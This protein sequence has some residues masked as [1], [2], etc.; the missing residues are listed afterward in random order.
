MKRNK[1]K[2]TLIPLLL[3]GSLCV[4]FPLSVS[5]L[6]APSS[7]SQTDSDILVSEE[8]QY[9]ED[10]SYIT[11]QIYESNSAATR[12][13]TYTKDGKKSITY[14]TDTGVQLW[15]YT[16]AG[17]FTVNPGVSATCTKAAGTPTIY[18]S[19]WSVVSN[20]VSRSGN[21]AKGV[22]TMQQKLLGVVVQKETETVTLTC[23]VN[24]VLS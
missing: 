13:S 16:V 15:K 1:L 7:I 14:S 9:L 2:R 21:K 3:A 19:S 20:N 24:G 22:I 17:Q 23:S 6:T 11:T 12:A 4:T 18:E 5:A 8:I 10:G